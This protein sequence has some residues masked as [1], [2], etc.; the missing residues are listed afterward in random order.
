VK[1]IAGRVLGEGHVSYKNSG[2]AALGPNLHNVIGRKAG[3][4]P[5]S[6][7][8]SAMKGADFVW[9]KKMLA[10]SRNP[11]SRA[12]QQHEAVWRAHISRGP[13]QGDCIPGV[14]HYQLSGIRHRTTP[15]ASSAT[16]SI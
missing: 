9:D 16:P 2:A 12:W 4:L 10:S 13:S 3:S 1:R 8:S 7:Y 14:D 5:N 15:K 6:S 11:V